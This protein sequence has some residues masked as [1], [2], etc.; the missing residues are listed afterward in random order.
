MKRRLMA[1]I[2][3]LVMGLGLLVW[4]QGSYAAT[5]K[6]QLI[7]INKQTNQ[8]AF[9]ENGKLIK[10]YPVATGRTP[11]LTPEGSFYVREKI[12][13][14][15]YY[16][17]HIKGGDPRNPLGNRWMGLS[18]S[19][20]GSYP[21]GIHGTN[22]ESSIGKHISGGCIRMHNKD[23]QELFAK[24]QTKAKVV[25]VTSKSTLTAIAKPYLKVTVAK[26]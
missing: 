15:P 1:V 17:L 2:V 18:A 20:H 21:Y 22:N 10:T 11:K 7:V 23:V 26:K 24:I 25:I 6:D 19:E 8:L 3:A 4:P 12:V 5:T 9:F 16:K 14:R 13:N